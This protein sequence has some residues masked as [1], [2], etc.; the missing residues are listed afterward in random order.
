[1]PITRRDFLA[2][3]AAA[4]VGG[5]LG[6]MPGCAKRVASTQAN[7]FLQACAAGNTERVGA[8]LELEPKLI[9]ARDGLGRSGFALAHLGQ[10]S[11][12]GERLLDAGYGPDLHE[13]ALAGAWKRLAQLADEPDAAPDADHPLGGGALL[14]GALGGH[15]ADLWQVY[16]AGASPNAMPRGDH[17]LSPL[18]AALRHPDPERAESSGHNL[19]SNAGDPNLAGSA[20]LPPLH[21]A[22]SRGMVTM[23]EVLIRHGA[24]L[25]ATDDQGRHALA[26]AREAGHAA[27][28]ALLE[29]PEQIPP[30]HSTSRLAYTADGRPYE[31]PPLEGLTRRRRIEMVVSAHTR[32]EAVREALSRD[33][34][35]AH[36]VATNGESAVEAGAHMGRKDI[37]ETLLDHGAPYALPTATMLGDLKRVEELL[38]EDPLRIHERG[39]HGFPLLWY[40]LLGDGDLTTMQLLLDRGGKVEQQH[41]LGTTALHLAAGRGR[42]A[43]VELL[44]E[45]GADPRRV[46]GRFDD[47]ATAIE[48][49]RR[50]GHDQVVALLLQ[51]VDR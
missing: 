10:H 49:A 42:T 6:G 33:S 36:A 5:L 30:A 47:P 37:V 3:G 26:V 2:T 23:V 22:A 9:E 8:L 17:G 50:A 28:V 39:P 13:A 31:A 1:M 45:H 46:G 20:D 40:P 51:G 41:L 27:A 34:R 19:A 38:D 18:Q 24:R 48:Q 14:A 44:I 4:G 11:A 12:V 43:M 21:I 35:L 16:A 15:G 7:A 25:D 32:L 29:H